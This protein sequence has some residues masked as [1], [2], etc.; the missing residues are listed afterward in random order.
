[1]SDYHPP[2][3]APSDE[4]HVGSWLT[5]S[6]RAISFS[7]SVLTLFRCP[8]VARQMLEIVLSSVVAT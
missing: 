3:C 1:M 2:S 4:A 6:Q 7:V 8:K 5:Y